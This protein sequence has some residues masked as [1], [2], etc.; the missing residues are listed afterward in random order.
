MP[1]MHS[2]NYMHPSKNLPYGCLGYC[3]WIEFKVTVK[4]SSRPL[5]T[6]TTLSVISFVVE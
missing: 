4:L 6:L 1:T 3:S 5:D 2:D